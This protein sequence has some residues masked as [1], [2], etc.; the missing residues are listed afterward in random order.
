MKHKLNNATHNINF[1][2]ICEHLMLYSETQEE[3]EAWETLLFESHKEYLRFI[4]KL[5]TD[6]YNILT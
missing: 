1:K 4:N 2:T 5:R 6:N 3:Y